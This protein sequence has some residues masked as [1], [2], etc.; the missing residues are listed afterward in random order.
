MDSLICDPPACRCRRARQVQP[1]PVKGIKP[2]RH[3]PIG[4]RPFPGGGTLPIVIR[5]MVPQDVI[6]GPIE[7]VPYLEEAKVLLLGN[8]EVTQLQ[9][10]INLLPPHL[11]DEHPQPIVGVVHDILM[12]VRDDPEP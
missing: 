5:V 1:A 12:N 8:T 11:L 4:H 10:E 6:L 2:G 9:N 7:G 3:P